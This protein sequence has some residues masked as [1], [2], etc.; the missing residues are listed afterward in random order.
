MPTVITSTIGTGGDYTTLQAW[1]DACPADLVAVDQIWRGEVLWTNSSSELVVSGTALIVSGVVT[2]ATRYIELTAVAGASFVD[3][4]NRLTN[5]LRYNANNGACIRKTGAYTDALNISSNYFRLSRL[6]FAV[7]DGDS[8][9]IKIVNPGGVVE[10][11]IFDGG[12]RV[13]VNFVGSFTTPT[14]RN[15]LIASGSSP[16]FHVVGLYAPVKLVNVTVV[17]PSNLGV[18]GTGVSLGFGE[19]CILKNCAI[20]GFTNPYERGDTRQTVTNLATDAA[21]IQTVNTMSGNLTGLTYANQ[22]EQPSNAGGVKDFRLKAGSALIDTGSNTSADGVTTDIV[23]T[24][25][26]ATYDIGAWEIV[27]SIIAA[28]KRPFIFRSY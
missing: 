15:C 9:E 8:Y 6:Q 21:S 14:M 1:E 24:A 5:A 23:G 7:D 20:F 19:F 25:R 26:G 4:A 17:R 27:S 22:F 12:G 13:I 2:D 10:N 18:S 3:N 28:I 16:A 11:C